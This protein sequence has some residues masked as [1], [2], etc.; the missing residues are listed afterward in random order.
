MV[1][2]VPH[3]IQF[4]ASAAELRDWFETNHATAPELWVGYYKKATG[5]PSVVWA[6]AV[7]EALCVGWIDGLAKRIDDRSHVQRFTP[8][9]AGSNWSAINVASVER[10]TGQGR[11]R[12]AGI[13]A[14]EARRADRTAIYAYEQ[15]AAEFSPA[16]LARFRAESGAWADWQARSASYRRSATHWVTSAK[17]P[18]TRTRRLSTLIEDSGAGRPIRLLSYA[19]TNG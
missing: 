17:R 1:K 6:E 2:L 9:R 14:F 11:M 18:E 12:P 4:F 5:L 10:L 8:R 3:D 13:A 15:D 16:E 7:E 19:R